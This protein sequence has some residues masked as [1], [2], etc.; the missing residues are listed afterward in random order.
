MASIF[1][2]NFE[3]ENDIDEDEQI[4]QILNFFKMPPKIVSPI[5]EPESFMTDLNVEPIGRMSP[6]RDFDPELVN[7]KSLTKQSENLETDLNVEPIGRMSPIEDLDPELDNTESSTVRPENFMNDLDME[8][9]GPMSPI[10]DLDP[11]LVTPAVLTEVLIVDPMTD[12][13]EKPT[14]EKPASDLIEEPTF[15]VNVNPASDPV[16]Q[17][18]D[19][20]SPPAQQSTDITTEQK[21]ASYFDLDLSPISSDGTT[22]E[23]TPEKFNE[24]SECNN[25]SEADY[26]SPASPKPECHTETKPCII[27][28]ETLHSNQ[29]HEESNEIQHDSSESE[30]NQIIQDYSPQFAKTVAMSSISTLSNQ[31]SYLMASLRNAIERYCMST[32]WT[33]ETVTKCV[34][35]MLLETRHVKYLAI[36]LLEVVEDTKEM[37][38]LEFTP[39]SPALAPSIQ[40]CIL[41]YSRLAHNIPKFNEYFKVMLERK[42]FTFTNELPVEALTNL[43]HFYIA[44]NDIDQSSHPANMRLFIYKCLYYFTHKCIPLVF[45]VLMAHPF[46]LPHANSVEFLTDPLNKAIVCA[47]TNITYSTDIKDRSY[48]KTEMFLTLK[49]RF[50]YFADKVFPIDGTIE[51][52]IDCIQNNRL[53]NIDYALILLAKRKG[54]EYAL[55]NIIHKY[56]IPL[57]HRYF[58]NDL[59]ISTQYDQQIMT[60]LLV[61]SSIVKTVP[62][63]VSIDDYVNLLAVALNATDRQIIQEAAISGM[64]Q[65]SRFGTTRIYQLISAWKPNYIKS[66]RITAILNTIVY[67]KPMNFWFNSSLIDVKQ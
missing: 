22:T 55:K 2:D 36:A 14:V 47:L 45:T 46:I 39:P 18:N 37:P 3:D 38:S 33:S 23:I 49:S 29:T 40:R 52:C 13:I 28:T 57:L 27:P 15:D 25:E 10:K 66:K 41:L 44:I 6:I 21:N 5:K 67:K 9:I 58:T 32:E 17:P 30:I 43:T 65:L 54:Y 50:G 4:R 26:Y 1:G 61:I 35:K 53:T 62:T 60:I 59:T 19:V 63:E 56:L 34:N 31:D 12:S 64:C 24:S 48:K 16:E 20:I 42:M 7:S 8:P 51:Y 11:E